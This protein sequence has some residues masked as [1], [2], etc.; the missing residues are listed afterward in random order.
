M[1]EGGQP[2]GA[3]ADEDDGF[4]PEQKR[5]RQLEEDPGFKIYLTMKRLR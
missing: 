2:G 5:K 3:A 1:P 4:T